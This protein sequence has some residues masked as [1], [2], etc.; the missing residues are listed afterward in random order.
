MRRANHMMRCT[1]VTP[2]QCD[3]LRGRFLRWACRRVDFRK[4]GFVLLF[5]LMTVFATAPLRAAD[6][7]EALAHFTTDEY[8][9]T[10]AG[11]TAI[12]GSGDPRAAAIIGALADGKLLF[13]AEQKTVF[14]RDAGGRLLDAM[15]GE[16]AAGPAPA[17]LAPVRINNRLRRTIDASMGALTLMS[18]DP[19]KRYEAAQAVFKSREAGALPALETAIAKE[20]DPRIKTTLM[21]ARAA[22]VL[23]SDEASE[24]DKIAAITSSASAATRI[25]SRCCPACPRVR[26]PPS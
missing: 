26:H 18:P 22:I 11:I 24:A 4:F 2:G 5:G 19:D 10:D 6:L 20:T 17:D 8:S 7:T 14:Y 3:A 25:R 1:A 21:Q 15:T 12:A 16:L 23:N 9:D 13:S